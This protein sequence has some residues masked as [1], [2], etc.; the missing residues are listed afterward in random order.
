VAQARREA[1]VDGVEGAKVEGITLQDLRHYYASGLIVAGCDVV[2]VQRAL[3]HSKATTTLNTYAHFWLTAE[4]RTRK[5]AA[6]MM[7]DVLGVADPLRTESTSTV[8]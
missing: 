8:L 2:T 1:K 6:S 7:V 4:D 3:G 5:A